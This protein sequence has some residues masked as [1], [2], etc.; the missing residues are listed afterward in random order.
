MLVEPRYSSNTVY[1]PVNQSSD[2]VDR[3]LN[4]KGIIFCF[5]FAFVKRLSEYMKY[6][7][8]NEAKYLLLIP[9]TSIFI[10]IKFLNR[11]K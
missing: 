6:A 9:R 11:R 8:S 2:T 4:V 10:K 5:C 7:Y 1:L 3:L